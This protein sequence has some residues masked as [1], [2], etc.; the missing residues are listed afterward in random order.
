MKS[1]L[2]LLLLLIA[3]IG[4]LFADNRPNILVMMVDDMG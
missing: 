3:A 4:S 2:L 1:P